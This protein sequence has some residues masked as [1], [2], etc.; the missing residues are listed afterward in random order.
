MSIFWRASRGM[1]LAPIALVFWLDARLETASL[2]ELVPQL[3]ALGRVASEIDA[4]LARVGLGGLDGAV[5][6][7][8]RLHAV[9]DAVSR[10]D[11]ERM[12]RQVEAVRRDLEGAARRI[13]AL[14]ELKV[15]LDG[16]TPSPDR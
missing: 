15:L 5:A 6:L 11:L 4:R 1:W 2:E 7:H 3:E 13:A 16:V 14:R 9:L 12:A 8:E 10:D